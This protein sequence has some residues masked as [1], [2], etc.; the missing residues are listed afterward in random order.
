MFLAIDLR[1]APGLQV[2]GKRPT[3]VSLVALLA[4]P[5]RFDG[6][7]VML[8]GYVRSGFESNALYLTKDDA[9]ILNRM[10]SVWL[11]GYRDGNDTA[12]KKRPVRGFIR[13]VGTVRY[14]SAGVGH[15]GL[16]PVGISDITLV[17]KTV[18]E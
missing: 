9:D 8:V 11:E 4:D 15:L 1:A 14:R 10:N 13:V 18:K 5:A 3:P 6:Q 17:V 12:G 7:Q 2:A 16:W